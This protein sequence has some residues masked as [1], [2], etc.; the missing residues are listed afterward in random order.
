MRKLLGLTIV[1]LTACTPMKAIDGTARRFLTSAGA[2]IAFDKAKTDVLA[3]V[4]VY[5]TERGYQEFKRTD[6]SGTN[7]VL[8]FKGPRPTRRGNTANSFV[9]DGI[10]SWFAVR[11]VG[12]GGKTTLT[13]YG[14]PTLD[15]KEAC[16]DGDRELKDAGYT[17]APFEERADWPGHQLVEGREETQVISTIIARLAERWQV[18]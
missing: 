6:V 5:M 12:E 14:K 2:T 7:H 15:G 18:N 9:S 11:V 17:C 4:Q 1:F 16:G 3:A 13:F 10:G 8:Y